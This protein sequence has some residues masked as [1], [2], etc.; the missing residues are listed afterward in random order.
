MY[1]KWCVKNLAQLF[2]DNVSS[3]YILFGQVPYG[4]QT[5]TLS[6][7]AST[8]HRWHPQSLKL[9]QFP[10]TTFPTVLGST[11][12]PVNPLE[13]PWWSFRNPDLFVLTDGLVLA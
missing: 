9:M 12:Y 11:V 3:A 6:P 2:N 8:H 7:H 13:R 10:D 5:L 1:L 4:G